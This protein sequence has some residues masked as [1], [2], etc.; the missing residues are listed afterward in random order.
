MHVLV[1]KQIDKEKVT[2]RGFINLEKTF[3]NVNW[4]TIFPTQQDLNVKRNLY[5]HKSA[6][7]TRGEVT[8][9]AKITKGVRQGYILSSSLYSTA[10]SKKQ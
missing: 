4:S 3:D 1:E 10:L 9:N 6:D 5:K 2:Y 7:I 8:A